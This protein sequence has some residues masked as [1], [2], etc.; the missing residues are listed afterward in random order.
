VKCNGNDGNCIEGECKC[1]PEFS[2]KYCECPNQKCIAPNTTSVILKIKRNKKES[3][4]LTRQLFILPKK[5]FLNYR[6]V[7]EMTFAFVN[8]N[9]RNL[10]KGLFVKNV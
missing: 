9:A 10:I 8:A 6:F 7:L 2:G 5:I 4:L 3:F 1:S